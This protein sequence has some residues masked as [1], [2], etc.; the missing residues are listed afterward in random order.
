MKYEVV[1]KNWKNSDWKFL[2]KKCVK[3]QRKRS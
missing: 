3:K 1:N 2:E